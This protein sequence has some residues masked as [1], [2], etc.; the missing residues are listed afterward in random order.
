MYK[1]KWKGD[2]KNDP[3]AKES[4][5]DDQTIYE[6]GFKAGE[7][8]GKGKTTVKGKPPTYHLWKKGNE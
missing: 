8:D 4:T 6:G 2:K 1:G 7:K 3:K 5:K